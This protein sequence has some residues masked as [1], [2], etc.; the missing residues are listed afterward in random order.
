MLGGILPCPVVA[1]LHQV[2]REAA[3]LTAVLSVQLESLAQW[4]D[5]QT[6]GL[7]VGGNHL[8]FNLLHHSHFTLQGQCELV[9]LVV[10]ND[11]R[12]TARHEVFVH[13][14]LQQGDECGRR[15]ISL[16]GQRIARVVSPAN[17]KDVVGVGLESFD[18]ELRR[19]VGQ[20][21]HGHTL[22]AAVKDV[23]H[24][25][26]GHAAFAFTG[27]GEYGEVAVA[28]SG[29]NSRVVIIVG[30]RLGA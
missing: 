4:G 3:G 23:E 14:S 17:G 25:G 12:V 30:H 18:G 10:A 26:I 7:R 21:L 19:F 1:L 20:R 8:H 6:D 15:G 11:H 27:T 28:L 24:H 16:C 5:D 22:V 13:L 2:L 9:V 29:S